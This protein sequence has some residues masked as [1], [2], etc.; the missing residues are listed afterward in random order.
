MKQC[1]MEFVEIVHPVFNFPQCIEE[2]VRF[3]RVLDSLTKEVM[4]LEL[5]MHSLISSRFWIPLMD[6]LHVLLFG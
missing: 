5:L 3:C 4:A 6:A 2:L 1:E